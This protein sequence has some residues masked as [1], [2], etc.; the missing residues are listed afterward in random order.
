MKLPMMRPLWLGL[1]TAA[2]SPDA[3]PE[4]TKPTL[5]A[6]WVLLHALFCAT[7]M[8]VGFRFSRLVVYLLFLPT[9][10]INPTAHLVSLVAPPVMLA[11]AN[12]TTTITTTTTRTTTTVTTTTVAAEIGTHPHRHGPVFVGRHPIRV[13][14]WPHPDPTEILKAHHI[15]AGAQNAQ[16]SSLRR[17]AGPPRPVIAVTPTAT[18]A[19]QV[20]SL[21]SIAHTLRLVDVP[22]TWIV[23]EPEHRTDAVAAV[24]SRSNLDFLHI[25]GPDSSTAQLRMHALREIRRRR[26]KGVVVFADEKSILRTELFDEAQ[27]VKS[28]GVVPVGVLG[29]DEG[30]NESFLQAPSCDATGNLVGYHVS[31]ETVLPANRGDMLLSSKLEWSGFVVNAQTLWEGSVEGRPEWVRDIDAIDDGAA[32]SP[33]ALVTDSARV[34]PLASCGQSALAWLLRSDT[35]HEA[36]FPHEWK[37]DPPT[38]ASRQQPA[39]PETPLKRTT[40]LNAQGQH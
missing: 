28:V 1:A 4:P 27:K 9:P 39:K 23:V 21:T 8:A 16:R 35:L 20:P 14:P 33:L 26:M 22:L 29:E 15:I 17:G 40:L 11:G 12:A 24:L 38:I 36:K 13:R 30:T 6:A 18:S 19:L 31:E 25:A 34:E 32:A 2:G 5:P 37:I 7:S 10:A 3:A